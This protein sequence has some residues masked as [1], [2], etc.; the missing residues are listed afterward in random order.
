MSLMWCRFK[1]RCKTFDLICSFNDGFWTA[2][3]KASKFLRVH[4]SFGAGIK[5]SHTNKWPRLL[6]K[7]LAGSVFSFG[8]L[9]SLQRFSTFLS[10]S[11]MY[12]FSHEHLPLAQEWCR[13]CFGQWFYLF[14]Y[15]FYYNSIMLIGNASNFLIKRLEIFS[16]SSQYGIS[17][18]INGLFFSKET[19]GIKNELLFLRVKNWCMTLFKYFGE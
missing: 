16:F 14:C 10:V 8:L 19:G 18:K 1:K 15:P 13:I 9:C 5:I 3:K 4:L 7:R 6:D 12:S 17:T 11:P 2:I